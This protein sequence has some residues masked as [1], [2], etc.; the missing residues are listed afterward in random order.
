MTAT[1]TA[2]EGL[3]ESVLKSSGPR[4]SSLGGRY[5][6]PQVSARIRIVGYPV[7]NSAGNFAG[8]FSHRSEPGRYPPVWYSATGE[9]AQPGDPDLLTA[10]AIG[11]AA[12]WIDDSGRE[13]SSYRCVLGRRFVDGG[14]TEDLRYVLGVRRSE[15]CGLSEPGGR[16]AGI[17]TEVPC[18]G[19]GRREPRPICRDHES[20]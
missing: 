8:E 4:C 13:A 3:R 9:S 14:E 1:A 19:C 11:L 10:H 15:V 17:A 7:R 16:L 5:A 18:R 6:T 20:P 12:D 2:D